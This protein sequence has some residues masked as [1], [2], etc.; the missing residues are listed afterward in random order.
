MNKIYFCG[1]LLKNVSTE[2]CEL[3]FNSKIK[4]GYTSHSLCKNFNLV[5]RDVKENHTPVV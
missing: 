3:C 2:E 5:I 4:S 1:K